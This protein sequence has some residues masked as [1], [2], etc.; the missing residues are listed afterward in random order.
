MK[1]KRSWP[2]RAE[3]V[4]HQ[5]AVD[6]DAAEVHRDRGL[7]LARAG[8]VGDAA[9]GREHGDLA[10]RADE[11]GL[12]GRERAGDDDLDRLAALAVGVLRASHVTAPGPRR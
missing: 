7:G 1:S 5:V 3:Q 4:E 6:R 12:A 11:R 9:L 10:D 2:G 8:L